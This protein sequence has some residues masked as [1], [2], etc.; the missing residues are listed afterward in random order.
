M[1]VV[2]DGVNDLVMMVVVGFGVVY[3][4]KFKVEVKV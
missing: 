4:V 1:V 3:Y 2:G